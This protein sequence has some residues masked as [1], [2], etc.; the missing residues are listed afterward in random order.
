MIELDS[1][2]RG[3]DETITVIPAKAGTHVRHPLNTIDKAVDPGLR[4]DNIVR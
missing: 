2:F 4:R 3:N 1:R